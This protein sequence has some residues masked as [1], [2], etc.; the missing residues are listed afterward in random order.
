MLKAPTSANA[1][2]IARL[3]SALKNAAFIIADPD[4]TKR[5]ELRECKACYYLKRGGVVWQA[6]TNAACEGCEAVMTFPNSR[7][8]KICVECSINYDRCKHCSGDITTDLEI[9][10]YQNNIFSSAGADTSE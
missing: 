5:A 1:I 4:K 9:D 3:K 8:D 10:T 2:A 7:A 6:F